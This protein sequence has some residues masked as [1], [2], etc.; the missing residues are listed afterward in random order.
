MSGKKSI[1]EARLEVAF[2]EG[3]EKNF[4][5]ACLRQLEKR[6]HRQVAFPEAPRAED[7]GTG[8]REGA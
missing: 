2:D 1:V 5:Q 3:Y 4:T 8:A 7:A 6:K